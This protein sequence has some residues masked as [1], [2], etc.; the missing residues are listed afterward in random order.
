MLYLCV[1]YS[2]V[3]S[4]SIAINWGRTSTEI[5]SHGPKRKDSVGKGQ[6]ARIAAGDVAELEE[7]AACIHAAVMCQ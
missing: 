3:L 2:D 1:V 7:E 5:C 6:E 4:Y